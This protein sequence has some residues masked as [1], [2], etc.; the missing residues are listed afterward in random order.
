MIIFK[1]ARE[2]ELMR[3]AGRIVAL[4]LQAVGLAVQPG[5]STMELDEVA[6]EAIVKEGALPAFKGLYGFPGNICLSVNSE[7]VH[8]IPGKRRLKEGDI[9]SVDIGALVEGYNG[10]AA[11]TFPVGRIGEEEARLLQVTEESLYKGLAEAKAGNRLG[12]VSHAVQAHAEAAGFGV[13][14]DYVGHGIGRKMHED[15]QI[16]NFGAPDKG[17]VLKSGMVIAIEPMIN[18]GSWKVKTLGDNWT[19]VTLDGKPSAHFEHTVAVTDQGPD[20]LTKL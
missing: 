9:I 2:I 18:L 12:A 13:V 10:D 17:P 6:R 8:G 16:P 7:V 11:R 4:A 14:R 19:V 3:L 1:S 15:P 5:V 20:I